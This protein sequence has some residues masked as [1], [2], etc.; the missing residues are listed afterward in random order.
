[1][2][3]LQW[4]NVKIELNKKLFFKIVDMGNACF[5]NHHFTEDIQ[6]REYRSP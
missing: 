2:K 6:T 3:I 4:K 1:M 5:A